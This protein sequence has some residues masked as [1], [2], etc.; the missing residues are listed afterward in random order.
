MVLGGSH[1]VPKFKP[2]L[3]MCKV[4]IAAYWATS[5][6]TYLQ[7]LC[8]VFIYS[9]KLILFLDSCN[10]H[11]TLQ[12]LG[13]WDSEYSACLA[14]NL[15]QVWSLAPLMVVRALPRVIPESKVICEHCHVRTKN[16]TTITTNKAFTEGTYNCWGSRSIKKRESHEAREIIF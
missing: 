7:L 16:K 13:R 6:P 5:P 14:R 2:W 10:L 9:Q 15:T 11:S 1:E 12:G 3:S 8:L 4:G